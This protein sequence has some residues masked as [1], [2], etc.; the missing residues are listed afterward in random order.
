MGIGSQG[1]EVLLNISAIYLN[2]NVIGRRRQR[3]TEGRGPAGRQ[4]LDLALA[5]WGKSLKRNKGGISEL[6]GSGLKVAWIRDRLQN[7]G[8]ALAGLV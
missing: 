4:G 2:N 7:S 3:T 1:I 8:L 5:D 6:L